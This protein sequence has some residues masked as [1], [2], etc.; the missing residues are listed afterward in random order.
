MIAADTF[1]MTQ[2]TAH[3]FINYGDAHPLDHGGLIVE[4]TT[5]HV[6]FFEGD[7]AED[8]EYLVHRTEL[9]VVDEAWIDWSAVGHAC[10]WPESE[11]NYEAALQARGRIAML[12]CAIGFYGADNFDTAPTRLTRGQLAQIGERC[13][14][15][16]L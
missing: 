14:N 11:R 2:A 13:A 8:A 15:F 1:S 3:P 12:Q 7:E 10:G 6:I 16:E 5:G 4:D 9:E